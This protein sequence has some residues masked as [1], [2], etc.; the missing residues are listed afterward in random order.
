MYFNNVKALAVLAFTSAIVLVA[1]APNPAGN[2]SYRGDVGDVGHKNENSEKGVDSKNNDNYGKYDKQDKE[3]HEEALKKHSKE[4]E[5]QKMLTK[6]A[7]EKNKAND[8][9]QKTDEY[10][11][12]EKKD[13]NTYDNK[14]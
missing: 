14:S 12:G 1:A 11:K 9:N 10:W 2:I 4:V 5:K 6:E 3:S 8:K 13:D 7:A